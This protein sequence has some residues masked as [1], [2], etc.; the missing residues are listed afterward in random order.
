MAKKDAETEEYEDTVERAETQFERLNTAAAGFG[1]TLTRTL[2][3]GI[4][5]GKGFEAILQ[6][7]GQKFI[8]LSLRAAFKPL[9]SQLGN[10][11][12]SFSSSL[13]GLFGSMFGGTSSGGDIAPSMADNGSAGFSSAPVTVNMAI[14]TPDVEGF[15]RSEA[16]VSASLARAVARGQRSL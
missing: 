4:A 16:Q 10:L 15:Q 8:E 1:R 13:G 9:E 3:S 12:G 14:S 11:L 7:L 6:S 5:H 2:A